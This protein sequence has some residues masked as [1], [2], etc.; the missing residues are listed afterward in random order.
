MN[1]EQS[2]RAKYQK[3]IFVLGIIQV[4][5]NIVNIVVDIKKRRLGK[6]VKH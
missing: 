6:R 3:I 2:K 4:V 1:K 5:L